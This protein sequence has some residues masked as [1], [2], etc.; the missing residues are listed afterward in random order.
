MEIFTDS[1]SVFFGGWKKENIL[2]LWLLKMQTYDLISANN[3]WS[4]I[5]RIIRRSEYGSG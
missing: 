5:A 2:L 4:P 1:A 3:V